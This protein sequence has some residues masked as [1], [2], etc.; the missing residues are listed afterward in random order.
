[1]FNRYLSK[2]TGFQST[3]VV[4]F[5]VQWFDWLWLWWLTP[6]STIFQLYRGDQFYCWKKSE[7]PDKTTDLP[8]VKS[9]TVTNFITFCCIEYTSSDRNSI[10]QR[11]SLFYWYWWN[12]STPPPPS[13][14]NLFFHSLFGASYKFVISYIWTVQSGLNHVYRSRTH[15]II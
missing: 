4:V 8:Q 7:Y 15:L 14:F 6:L 5:I 9:L 13:P 10:S 1:M 3:Y 2:V 12:P 11:Y